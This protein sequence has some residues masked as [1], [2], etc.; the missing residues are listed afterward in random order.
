MASVCST[1][2][3]KDSNVSLPRSVSG[4][5]QNQTS[6]QETDNEINCPWQAGWESP[7]K[8]IALAKSS[9][10][11]TVWRP[12]CLTQGYGFCSTGRRTE[13]SWVSLWLCTGPQERRGPFFNPLRIQV[14][15]LYRTNCIAGSW[16]Q[17]CGSPSCLQD[18]RAA[19][20]KHLEHIL[21]VSCAAVPD[22]R[23]KESFLWT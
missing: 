6:V 11:F 16:Y 1:Q 4:S 10:P 15:V 13:R 5:M 18:I 8:H 17:Q 7:A 2:G 19:N 3:V 20:T 23:S 9:A 12:C 22:Y 14:T 21:T